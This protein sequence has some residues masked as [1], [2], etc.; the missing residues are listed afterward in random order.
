MEKVGFNP[1]PIDVEQVQL[2]RMLRSVYE[3]VDEVSDEYDVGFI[4]G[5]TQLA[6]RVEK[7]LAE[8]SDAQ[9]HKIRKLYDRYA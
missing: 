5:M 4:S 8:F 9:A 3:S 1:P 7:G 6:D 2:A